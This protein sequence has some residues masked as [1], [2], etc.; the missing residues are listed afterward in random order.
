[1]RNCIIWGA[2]AVYIYCS[3]LLLQISLHYYIYNRFV[4]PF[5]YSA[6]YWWI[7]RY[8]R[9]IFEYPFFCD[10]TIE[11]VFIKVRRAGVQLRPGFPS[12]SLGLYTFVPVL[13]L[14]YTANGKG[15]KAEALFARKGLCGAVVN[16]ETTY[17][18]EN[19]RNYQGNEKSS[20]QS[21]VF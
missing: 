7:K 6:Q 3:L 10:S 2:T 14:G 4:N 9:Y 17:S 11:I 8:R 16:T 21:L 12:R 20:R 5:I 18:P 13:R 15:Y 19:A 1:M